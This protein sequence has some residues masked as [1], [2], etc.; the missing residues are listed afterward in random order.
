MKNTVRV[1][2]VIVTRLIG[3]R[4]RLYRNGVT[5]FMIPSLVS[6]LHFPAFG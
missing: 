5:E 2:R 1:T 6:T 3:R 4:N